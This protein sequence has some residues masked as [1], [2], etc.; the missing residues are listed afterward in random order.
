MGCGGRAL[1]CPDLAEFR[2]RKSAAPLK[3]EGNEAPLKSAWYNPVDLARTDP[4]YFEFVL[5]A[6]QNP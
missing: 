3:L 5:N 1:G 6:L 4:Y 2:A